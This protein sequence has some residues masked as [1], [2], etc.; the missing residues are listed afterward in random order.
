MFV[1]KKIYVLRSLRITVLETFHDNWVY[2]FANI[3]GFEWRYHVSYHPQS[4]G[5]LEVQHRVLKNFLF[6]AMNFD[7]NG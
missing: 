1:D 7:V 3:K 5:A 6:S 4:C 2:I